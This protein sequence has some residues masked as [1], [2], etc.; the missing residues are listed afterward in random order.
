MFVSGLLTEQ[1]PG[2]LVGIIGFDLFR[3]AVVEMGP[4]EL[5]NGDEEEM[6]KS[7]GRIKSNFSIHLHDPRTYDKREGEEDEYR[8]HGNTEKDEDNEELTMDENIGTKETIPWQKLQLVS[9]AKC[10]SVGFRTAVISA[11]IYGI[12]RW[13]CEWGMHSLLSVT[14]FFCLVY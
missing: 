1:L 6:E 7:E 9:V 11:T 2:P 8:E 10:C 3:S 14:C 5:E 13:D 12:L 4:L